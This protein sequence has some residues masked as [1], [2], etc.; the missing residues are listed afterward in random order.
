MKTLETLLVSATSSGGFTYRL[1]SLKPRASRSK[2]ASNKL[3]YT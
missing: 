1:Y 3:W 2:G